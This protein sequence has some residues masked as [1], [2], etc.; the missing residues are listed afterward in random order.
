[1]LF[2]KILYKFSCTRNLFIYF[3]G[4]YSPQFI[5]SLNNIIHL[6]G[7]LISLKCRSSFLKSCLNNNVVPGYISR[8]IQKIKCRNL[9][10]VE[11]AF[12]RDEITFFMDSIESLKSHIKS[13]WSYAWKYLGFFDKFRFAK[14]LSINADTLFNQHTANYNKFLS[15]LIKKKFGNITTTDKHIFNFSSHVLSESEKLVLSR[16]LS[17]CNP[18]YKID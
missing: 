8:R 5:R 16:G 6:R 17:F 15:L 4:R 7:K 11:R 9:T 2:F 1:M 13:S 18:P 3:R 10:N 12:I 14:Y